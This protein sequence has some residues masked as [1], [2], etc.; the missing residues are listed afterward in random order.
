MWN[1]LPKKIQNVVKKDNEEFNLKLEQ[2]LASE[3]LDGLYLELR[4]F[5]GRLNRNKNLG[6]FIMRL[7]NLQIFLQD[8]IMMGKIYNFFIFRFYQSTCI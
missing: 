2:D 3:V 8:M 5:Q 1:S 4:L 6:R 7:E